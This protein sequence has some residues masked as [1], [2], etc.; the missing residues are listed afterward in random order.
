MLYSLV[1][2][3]KLRVELDQ[4]LHVD[5]RVFV[6]INGSPVSLGSLFR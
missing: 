3:I 1:M 2:L 6:E 5:H 4:I